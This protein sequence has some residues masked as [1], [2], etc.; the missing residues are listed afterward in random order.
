MNRTA[1]LA[2]LRELAIKFFHQSDGKGGS[3]L[4][5]W[6]EVCQSVSGAGRRCGRGG[7]V[8][9]SAGSGIGDGGCVSNVV[10]AHGSSSGA[11]MPRFT[12]KKSPFLPNRSLIYE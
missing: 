2:V 10:F 3:A 11:V 5:G 6:C 8:A 1:R 12:K 7:C 4:G 9:G